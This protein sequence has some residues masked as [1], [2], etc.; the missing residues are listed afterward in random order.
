MMQPATGV[1]V[2]R[3]AAPGGSCLRFTRHRIPP[4]T[5]FP[6]HLRPGHK[7]VYKPVHGT[8]ACSPGACG[9]SGVCVRACA[10]GWDVMGCVRA[11]VCLCMCACVHVCVRACARVRVRARARACRVCV[12]VCVCACVVC[13]GMWCNTQVFA[14][15]LH[16]SIPGLRGVSVV[17]WPRNAYLATSQPHLPC[18]PRVP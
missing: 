18:G 2:G 16:R 9:L 3:N 11:C 4:R 5:Y 15:A 1:P 10:L 12:D 17:Q 8:G 6:K 13:V 14:D 7:R